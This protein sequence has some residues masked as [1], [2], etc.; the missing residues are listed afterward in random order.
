MQLHAEVQVCGGY[1]APNVPSDFAKSSKPPFASRLLEC[2]VT[3]VPR[4]A[5]GCIL[6]SNHSASGRALLTADTWCTSEL[7]GSASAGGRDGTRGGMQANIASK[8][9]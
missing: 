4:Q 2:D 5:L 1:G 3:R 8:S 6:S 9:K 7:S